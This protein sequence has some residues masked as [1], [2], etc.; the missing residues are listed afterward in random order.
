MN[1][2]SPNE[3]VAPVA[4]AIIL[5]MI[6]LVRLRRV[7]LAARSGLRSKDG[8]SLIEIKGNFALETNG[9]GKISARG[10]M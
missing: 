10:K 1:V 5:I 6:P 4:V 9:V 7:V 2:L 8:G 3:T